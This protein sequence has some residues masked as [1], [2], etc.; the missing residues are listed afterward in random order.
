MREQMLNR[1]LPK[2]QEITGLVVLVIILGLFAVQVSAQSADAQA[3]VGS[4]SPA[5][6]AQVRSA[7]ATMSPQQIQETAAKLGVGTTQAVVPPPGQAP[8]RS[9]EQPP[10]ADS[11]NEGERDQVL[12]V[13]PGFVG[14]TSVL[15]FGQQLLSGRGG[16]FALDVP[17]PADYQIGPGDTV[18]LQLF[19]KDNRSYSLTVTR[20]GFIQ[21]PELGPVVVSGLTF[22]EMSR[23][24]IDRIGKQK[25][26]VDVSVSM[27]PLRSIQIFLLGDV[28]NP[29][30]YTVPALTTLGNALLTAGGVRPNG[31][32]RRIE[33]RRGG[34]TLTRFD[35]YDVLLKGDARTDLRLQPAD[36]IFVPPVGKRV[37][38]Q[39]EINRPAIYELLN[40]TTGADLL[41][42]SGGLLPTANPDAAKIIR[43]LPKRDSRQVI[44]VS[45]AGDK[46]K[47][48]KLADG[49]I[50]TVPG[51]LHA[52]RGSVELI[53]AVER[54]GPYGWLE[55]MT[56]SELVPS[57]ALLK[58]GAWRSFILVERRD[59]ISG[60]PRFIASDLTGVLRGEKG[61][62]LHD[63]DK[64]YVFD[65]ED[66]DAM[67]AGSDRTFRLPDGRVLFVPALLQNVR[68]VVELSGAV[69]HPGPYRW[70]EGM[71]LADLLP[72]HSELKPGAW[73]LLVMIERTDLVTG[74]RQYRAADL[75]AALRGKSDYPLNEGDRVYVFGQQ[76][77]EFISSQLLQSA[78]RGKATG[79]CPAIDELAAIAKSEGIDRFRSALNAEAPVSDKQTCP[80]IFA[81][82]SQLLLATLE[83]AV[84]VRGE[85]Q[86]PGFYLIASGV[87]LASAI[88]A[89]GG[90]TAVADLTAIE[91]SRSSVTQGKISVERKSYSF[92]RAQEVQLSGGDIIKVRK[93]F[94]ELD[95]GVV[96]VSGEVAAPGAYDIRRGERL[97]EVLLRAGGLTANAYPFGTVFQRHRVKEAQRAFYQRS[98]IEVQ[99]T[100]LL[101]LTRGKRAAAAAGDISVF[102]AMRSFAD[103]LK[104]V[105]PSGRIVVEA[106]PTVLQ[107]RPELDVV[108]EPG[109]VIHVPKRP[110]HV[111]VMGEVLNPG[112]LQFRSGFQAADYIRA[113][114]GIAETGDAARTFMILPNGSAEPLKISSWNAQPTPIPPG[115][116]IYVP[117]DPL[118][119]DSV[120]MFQIALEVAKDL[121]LTAASLY[122]ISR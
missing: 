65:R 88:E 76:D 110:S 118:P 73:R 94:N 91:F 21:V 95:S 8:A 122:S 68:G 114:G 17:V 99:N 45:L 28:K 120:T 7:A 33:L 115:S 29:G 117:R 27:G 51:T 22:E 56:L 77:I 2:S 5:Q 24:I 53:G 23:M 3:I 18:L 4:L 38:I 119:L 59:P 103:E 116:V 93:R 72:S 43:V 66:L 42:L 39:G 71:T 49:D 81:N 16:G 34:R 111:I 113:A 6:A 87:S 64:V 46:A 121:A 74:L 112:A 96:T 60:L 92:D 9:G 97:S 83:Y 80:P 58:P 11:R 44:S 48:V 41:R 85:V 84:G 1:L 62:S 25:I 82:H 10:S 15:P 12:L 98:S 31:S 106:D 69:R 107:V 108:L 90:L 54:P 63:E 79:A 13:P 35:L 105:E 100:A 101:M 14:H 40:E 89:A 78:L 70:R 30:A 26:G 52:I 50:L 32:L 102:Q 61:M 86:R 37:A 20:D 57:A 109:D 104:Q 36:V 75:S 67:S 19:G 55:G 47:N